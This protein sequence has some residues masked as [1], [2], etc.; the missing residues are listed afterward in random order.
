MSGQVAHDRFARSAKSGPPA[1]DGARRGLHPGRRQRPHRRSAL[2]E[3]GENAVAN[4][5][6]GR[7][8]TG[9]MLDKPVDKLVV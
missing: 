6:D 9:A 3:V 7:A 8:Q 2:V 4:L 5:L 1:T